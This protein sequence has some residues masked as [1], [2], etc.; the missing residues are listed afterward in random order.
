MQGKIRDLEKALEKATALPSA[1]GPFDAVKADPK[2]VKA[3]KEEL[4]KAKATIKATEEKCEG[5]HCPADPNV[6]SWPLSASTRLR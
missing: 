1:G 5:E 4:T 3:L 6:Q 2:E